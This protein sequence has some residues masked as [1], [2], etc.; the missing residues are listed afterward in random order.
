M[1]KEETRQLVAAML[2]GFS[3]LVVTADCISTLFYRKLS[4][5]QFL[6]T[7]VTIAAFIVHLRRYLNCRAEKSEE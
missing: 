2:F 7:A 1:K 6:S 5:L 3:S 4:F